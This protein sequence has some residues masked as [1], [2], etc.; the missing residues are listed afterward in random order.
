MIGEILNEERIRN[1]LMGK[2][3]EEVIEELVDLICGD[4][5]SAHP[6]FEKKEMIRKCQER[7]GRMS[8][9]IGK[10]VALPRIRGN[11]VNGI[12]ASLGIKPEGIE[13]QALDGNPVRIFCLIA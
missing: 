9:G 11:E 7:E 12:F 6:F 13:F 2:T 3:K 8:T 10:G 1:P 5:P 4:D